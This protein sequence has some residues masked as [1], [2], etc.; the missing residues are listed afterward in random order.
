MSPRDAADVAAAN[1][2]GVHG[3]DREERAAGGDDSG[4]A[5]TSD[6]RRGELD[7]GSDG[8]GSVETCA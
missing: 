7:E 3:D 6:V 2:I 8:E 1:G 5:R 4:R